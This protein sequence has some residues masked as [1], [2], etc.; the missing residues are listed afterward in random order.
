[1]SG[2]ARERGRRDGYRKGIG[3]PGAGRDPA[4]LYTAKKPV[5]G[6]AVV[7]VNNHGSDLHEQLEQMRDEH[8]DL[9]AAIARLSTNAAV[10]SFHIRRLK[11][12]KLKLKDSIARMESQL[13]PDLDA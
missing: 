3:Y 10:D 7:M 12:R 1:M 6:E 13:I 9:D 4:A 5:F 2:A 8:R 11:K